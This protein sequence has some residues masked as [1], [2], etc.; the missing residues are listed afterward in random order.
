MDLIDIVFDSEAEKTLQ[1]YDWPGNVRE[2][3]NVLERT[4]SRIEGQTITGRPAVFYFR[5]TETRRIWNTDSIRNSGKGRKGTITDCLA[6]Y[7]YN[8]AQVAK[9]LGI[10]DTANI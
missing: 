9:V 2:L 3:S 7:G 10:P 4:L 8:K 6:E 1:G 5:P